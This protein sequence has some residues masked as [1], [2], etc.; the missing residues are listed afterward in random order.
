MLMLKNWV[1]DLK[2]RFRISTHAVLLALGSMTVIFVYQ[3]VPDRETPPSSRIGEVSR[4]FY[5]GKYQF[6][7]GFSIAGECDHG[8]DSKCIMFRATLP[9]NDEVICF[10]LR[11]TH[12]LNHSMG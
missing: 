12:Y 1:R 2:T 11:M 6:K 10:R 5:N 7:H 9:L 3:S 8:H 4:L